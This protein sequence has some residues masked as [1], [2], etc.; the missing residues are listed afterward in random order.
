MTWRSTWSGGIV[1]PL[2]RGM[3]FMAVENH[4]PDPTVLP[5]A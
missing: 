3:R 4:T 5:R 2:T 1:V